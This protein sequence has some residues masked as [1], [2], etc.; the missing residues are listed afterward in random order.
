MASR[1]RLVEFH[2]LLAALSVCVSVCVHHR[3]GVGCDVSGSVGI[4]VCE[5]SMGVPVYQSEYMVC[6][7]YL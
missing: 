1:D 3:F 5:L 2:T 6:A 4:T 7:P